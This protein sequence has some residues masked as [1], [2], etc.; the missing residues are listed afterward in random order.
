MGVDYF[1]NIRK[2]KVEYRGREE[3][4][5]YILPLGAEAIPLNAHIGTSIEIQYAHEINCVHCGR[6]TQRS[7][8]QGYCYPCY[9]T[10][11]QTDDCILHPERCRAHQGESRDMAWSEEHCL[12]DHFVYLAL[13]TEVKVGVTRS[14]QI[15]VRWIDQGA[16]KAVKLAKTPNRY[17]AGM[18]EVALKRHLTDKTNW[19]NMLQNRGNEGVDLI[20]ERDKVLEFLPSTY[21]KYVVEGAD[22]WEIKYPAGSLPKKV[23]SVNLDNAGRFRGIL[24]G[25]KGQYLMLESGEVFN[26]RRHGGYKV[27]IHFGAAQ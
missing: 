10:L 6:K 22:V 23:K 19:R 12:Q 17:L 13:S 15:P 21:Q 26:V 7:Y 24:S 27:S 4:V 9:L 8:F 25:I 16:W 2:M 1:G 20:R 3:D 5:E 14:S 18:I 11:P